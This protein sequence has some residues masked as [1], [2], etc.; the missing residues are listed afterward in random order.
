MSRNSKN[1][2]IFE[3]I[4]LVIIQFPQSKNNPIGNIFWLALDRKLNV[5]SIQ[6]SLK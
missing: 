1:P 5:L 4:M 2:K 3:G 6:S